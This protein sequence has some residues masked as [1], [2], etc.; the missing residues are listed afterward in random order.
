MAV[1][2]QHDEDFRDTFCD[3]QDNGGNNNC[4]ASQPAFYNADTQVTK[5]LYNAMTIPVDKDPAE[6]VALE[7]IM[8]NMLG[9]PKFRPMEASV[10]T[11]TAGI[12]SWMMRRSYLARKNALG[13]LPRLMASWRMPGGQVSTWTQSL[14]EG[15]GINIDDISDNPSYMEIVNAVTVDRFNS[16]QYA[17][18]KVSD[19]GK[20]QLEKLTLTAFYLMQLRDY[21]ELLERTALALSVQ[22]A[23][24]AEDYQM[25]KPNMQAP[26]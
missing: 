18:D 4:G 1:L 3:P 16:G 19:S 15:A 8:T 5:R 17:L 20:Q 2:K 7:H 26:K 11:S 10:V 21:F 25:S 23:V 13:A 24:M 6:E 9:R 22:V 14:R 12:E